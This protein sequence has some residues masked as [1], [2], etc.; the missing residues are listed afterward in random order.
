[1]LIGVIVAEPLI[2]TVFQSSISVNYQTYNSDQLKAYEAR[3]ARCNPTDPAV[4]PPVDCGDDTLALADSPVS[5]AEK[6]SRTTTQRNQL[7]AQLTAL[8]KQHDRLAQIATDECAGTVGPG[9]TGV[10]GEGQQCLDDKQQAKDYSENN[11]IPQ[12]S[13]V[14]AGLNVEINQLTQQKQAAYGSYASN[15]RKAVKDKVANRK[16]E[17]DKP[18]GL[19]DADAALGRLAAQ[20][21]FVMAAEWFLR[22]LLVAIDLLPVLVKVLGGKTT[23]DALTAHQLDH[24]QQLHQSKMELAKRK[25]AGEYRVGIAAIESDVNYQIG[26]IQESDRIR[27]A[28][29]MARKEEEV[30]ALAAQLRGMGRAAGAGSKLGIDEMSKRVPMNPRPSPEMP[31]TVTVHWSADGIPVPNPHPASMNGT[32]SANGNGSATG[33]GQVNGT[34]SLDGYA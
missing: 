21:F 5:L 12:K 29:K 4:I 24:S 6:L 26:L 28:G 3:L 20:S 16:T 15:V 30:A 25:A 2:M 32:S 17:L 23:Y 34:G 19:L 9:L 18:L 1:V 10:R 8:N 33:N 11:Q 22:A 27:R 7:Q 31:E 14:L 13:K